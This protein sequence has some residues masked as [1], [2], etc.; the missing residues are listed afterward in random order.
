MGNNIDQDHRRRSNRSRVNRRFNWT[1]VRCDHVQRDT[2]STGSDRQGN[3]YIIPWGKVLC[4][5]YPSVGRPFLGT[6]RVSGG[7]LGGTRGCSIVVTVGDVVPVHQ[8]SPLEGKRPS[9]E[10]S[11]PVVGSQEENV[12]E[13]SHGHSVGSVDSRQNDGFRTCLTNEYFRE[14]RYKSPV[15]KQWRRPTSSQWTV[16]STPE[17]PGLQD[18]HGCKDPERVH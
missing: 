2:W 11:G 18:V 5:V 17:N 8:R 7:Q 12:T 9:K 10:E 14:S 13:T 4:P 1:H 6:A 15:G 16:S 3:Y